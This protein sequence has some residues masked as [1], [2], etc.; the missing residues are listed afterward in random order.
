MLSAVI[1]AIV[2]VSLPAPAQLKFAVGMRFGMNLGTLSFNPDIY[3]LTGGISK[4]GRTGILIGAVSEM[5]FARMFAVEFSPTFIMKGGGYQDTQGGTDLGKY[6]ELDLPILF[7]VKFLQGMVRP[8][9][10]LGPNIG[11]VMSATN[12]I[13]PAQGQGQ[14]IDIK[15][16]TSGIDFALTFGGGAEIE[17]AKQFG[18]I[19]DIRYELG[20]SDLNSPQVAPQQGQLV[21]TIKA[22]GFMIVVG[23]LFHIQ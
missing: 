4:T 11:I 7:K 2:L 15:N 21:P 12:S 1:C 5:E 8:Y 19:A 23:G 22:S 17:I 9:G 13:T 3:Q 16:N 20:L 6:S 14:D 18:I 10:F